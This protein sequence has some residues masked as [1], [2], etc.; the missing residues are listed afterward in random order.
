MRIFH[1][2]AIM[3]VA[4]MIYPRHLPHHRQAA[5]VAVGE[6]KD[7]IPKAAEGPSPHH[8]RVAAEVVELA[9]TT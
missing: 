7:F 6:M 4:V 1:E 5:V 9:D 3:A 8:H 2:M